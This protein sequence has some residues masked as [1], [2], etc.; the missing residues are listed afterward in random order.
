MWQRPFK[1]QLRKVGRGPNNVA[2]T[3][4]TCVQDIAGTV[5]R[6]IAVTPVF[7]RTG[8]PEP[9]PLIADLTR[10]AKL[11]D[12][13]RFRSLEQGLALT[14]GLSGP[15]DTTTLSAHA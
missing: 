11:I 15:E 4:P 10:L 9:S 5:G 3:E 7:E 1:S 8:R 2:A 12:L 14:M 6:L 13:C